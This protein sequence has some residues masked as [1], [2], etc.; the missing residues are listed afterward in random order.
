MNWKLKYEPNNPTALR[1]ARATQPSLRMLNLIKGR[2]T[3]FSIR[4]KAASTAAE[5]TNPA[6]V[7][8]DPQPFPGAATSV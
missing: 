5:A 8:T 2:L 1:F 3:R 4:A 7:A 6:I